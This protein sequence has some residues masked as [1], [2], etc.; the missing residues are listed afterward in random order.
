MG[1]HRFSTYTSDGPR[2]GDLLCVLRVNPMRDQLLGCIRGSFASW[3]R[4]VRPD[5]EGPRVGAD[6]VR[7]VVRDAEVVDGREQAAV[8]ERVKKYPRTVERRELVAG[9]QLA[10]RRPAAVADVERMLRGGR[11]DPPGNPSLSR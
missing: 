4:V 3:V 11:D 6:E 10:G 2:L 5:G 9:L 7:V 1:K 8:G